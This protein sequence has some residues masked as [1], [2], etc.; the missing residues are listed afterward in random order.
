MCGNC[1]ANY[2][3]YH[4]GC[5][6]CWDGGYHYALYFFKFWLCVLVI[7]YEAYM[8]L[9]KEN[10][11][12]KCIIRLFVNHT[13]YLIAFTSLNLNL[14]DDFKVVFFKFL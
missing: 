13:I 12:T 14:N 5:F 2:G 11:V 8:A 10:S 6:D 7:V 1:D 3:Q 9:Q 4:S